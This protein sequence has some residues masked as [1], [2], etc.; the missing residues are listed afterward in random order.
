MS[1]LHEVEID[2]EV[3]LYSNLWNVV[4]LEHTIGKKHTVLERRKEGPGPDFAYVRWKR[5]EICFTSRAILY[6]VETFLDGSK[7]GALAEFFKAVIEPLPLASEK[8]FRPG[9]EYILPYSDTVYTVLMSVSTGYFLRVLLQ[10]GRYDWLIL[11]LSLEK[12]IDQTPTVRRYKTRSLALEDF[13][14]IVDRD[15]AEC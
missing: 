6:S 9:T 8:S 13:A 15:L 11:G 7:R 2:R 5:E 14:T 10:N 4:Q 1:Y 3:D 12:E